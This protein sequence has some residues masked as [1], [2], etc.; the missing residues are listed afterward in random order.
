VA[1]HAHHCRT[2]NI[3]HGTGLGSHKATWHLTHLNIILLLLQCLQIIER[4]HIS[5]ISLRSISIS[6]QLLEFPLLVQ[7]VVPQILLQSRMILDIINVH[8]L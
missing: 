5:A 7:H 6:Q 1:W 4:I 3:T 8:A 2:A